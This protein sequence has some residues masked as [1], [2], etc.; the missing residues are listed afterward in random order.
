MIDQL[1]HLESIGF[2]LFTRGTC[3]D[4]FLVKEG[5]VVA[6]VFNMVE[7]VATLSKASKVIRQ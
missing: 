6:R 4:S 7:I 1:R 5:L 2:D 3:F